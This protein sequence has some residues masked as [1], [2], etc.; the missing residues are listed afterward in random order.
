MIRKSEYLDESTTLKL[1]AGASTDYSP[2]L[3]AAG[4]TD[5]IRTVGGLSKMFGGGPARDMAQIEVK[6]EP[7]GARVTINGKPL[8]KT[9]PVVIQV[10]P[11]NYDLVLEK[12]GY[13]PLAK[14]VSASTQDKIKIKESLSK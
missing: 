4:R 11:G 12:D 5:N 14:S 10:E 8:E 7:K 9:T 6:T 3:R 2:T 1:A 13:K